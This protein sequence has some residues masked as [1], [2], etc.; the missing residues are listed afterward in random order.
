MCIL[1]LS[2]Y[3]GPCVCPHTV[4]GGGGYTLQAATF[5][6][7]P[8]LLPL[9]GRARKERGGGGVRFYLYIEVHAMV[10]NRGGAPLMR[11]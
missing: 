7:P 9:G 2:P 5:P 10:I 8:P 4:N 6:P 11:I 3:Q 1:F